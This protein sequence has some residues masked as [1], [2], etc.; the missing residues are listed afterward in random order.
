[1]VLQRGQP[2]PVWGKADPGEN[3]TVEIAGQKQNVQ[4]DV[5]GKW[6]VKLAP[7]SA[8]EG[9][10]LR[11]SGS[12]T[13][14]PVLFDDVAVGEVW[15]CSGQSNMEFQLVESLNG[16]AEVAAANQPQI[17]LF[18]VGRAISPVPLDSVKG[19]WARC[20]P[21]SSRTFTAVGYFFGREV[22]SY[23]HVPVGLIETSWGG[24]VAESW[25]RLEALQN[26]PDYAEILNRHSK[27]LSRLTPEGELK[28]DAEYKKA[29][30]ELVAWNKTIDKL[31]STPGKP[32]SK[33]F[34][35]AAE[36]K[37]WKSI[38]EPGS[39]ESRVQLNIDGVVWLRKVV[40]VPADV[41]IQPATLS[42][43][44]VDDFDFTWLNGKVI[45]HTGKETANSW[46]TPRHYNIPAGELKPGKNVIMVRVIDH[47][48]AGGLT[49][50]A[51][52]LTLSFS[53]GQ[54]ISLVGTWQYWIEQ[55][56]GLRPEVPVKDDPNIASF[57]YNGMV[58]PLIPYGIRGV[59]WYQGESNADRAEQYL[60]LFPNMIQNW[61]Q[62]W[63]Q[64]DFSFYFVQLANFMYPVPTPADSAWAELRDAQFKT[65]TL[66]ETGMALAIDV[67]DAANIHPKNKQEVGR[68]LALWALA[69]DYGITVPSNSLGSWPVIK[70]F[71]QK[72]IVSS[73]P[74]YKSSDVSG[75]TIRIHF[76]YSDSGLVVKGAPAVKLK[77]FAIAGEDKKFVWADAIVDG[78]TVLV[79]SPEVS[80]PVAVRYAWANNPDGN[81]YNVEGLPASPFRTDDWPYSTAG[82]R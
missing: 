59:I 69:K 12:A 48:G 17:R 47:G 24:T 45:G 61:R 74:L 20:T 38:E 23:I 77:A 65:L 49:G 11:V 32:D 75:S 81:L 1:M 58:A 22:Q 52:D 43:G 18:H 78:S 16:E 67:G 33:W 51:E 30:E 26:D 56:L 40:E 41:A 71:F 13:K 21:E 5:S 79:S 28:A 70:N 14:T 53:G 34:E 31:L 36:P 54:S 6:R 8:G 62:D 7:I 3:V 2:I 68:R 50:R 25:T 9:Y 15:I 66:P 82:H 19:Q 39:W 73:G 72:P 76:D 35:T 42:L 80:K 4:A 55:N 46:M 27:M 29:Q 10:Q 64:G 44:T 57:L 60:K 37:D 63:A